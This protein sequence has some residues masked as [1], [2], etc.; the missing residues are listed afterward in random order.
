M[1][2]LVTFLGV[3]ATLTH[4]MKFWLNLS[5]INIPYLVY[6]TKQKWV[7]F[8]NLKKYESVVPRIVLASGRQEESVDKIFNLLEN[9]PID[10]E[11]LALLQ[12][13]FEYDIPGHMG[14]GYAILGQYLYFI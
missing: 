10:Y 6:K 9:Q 5:I 12:N 4:I 3:L 13:V 1:E 14:R 7:D 2:G 11:Q 8:Q